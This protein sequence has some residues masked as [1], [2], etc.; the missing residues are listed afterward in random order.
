MF[1]FQVRP[2]PEHEC[3]GL[4]GD[5]RHFPPAPELRTPPPSC[6]EEV[7]AQ[8]RVGVHAAGARLKQTPPPLLAPPLQTNQLGFQ[9]EFLGRVRL[10]GALASLA[11]VAPALLCILCKSPLLLAC[12]PPASRLLVEQP[13]CARALANPCVHWAWNT[14]CALRVADAFAWPRRPSCPHTQAWP[15]TMEP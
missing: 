9:P 6:N 5:A 8:G 13:S 7:H 12:T 11:G 3:G 14:A 1:F 4:A 10:A 2:L 15:C